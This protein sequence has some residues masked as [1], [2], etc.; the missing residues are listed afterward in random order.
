MRGVLQGAFALALAGCAAGGSQMQTASVAPG[1]EVKCIEDHY[2]DSRRCFAATFGKGDAMNAPFQVIY[3]NRLGPFLMVGYHTHPTMS[4]TVRVDD[5]KVHYIPT[6]NE[7]LAVQTASEHT[8]VAN[9]VIDDLVK[10]RTAYVTYY[11]WPSAIGKK[12]QVDLTGFAPAYEHLKKEI[13]KG[14]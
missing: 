3:Q 6:L 9:R 12:M 8:A 1:W 14:A 5:G 10:G 11:S 7:F 2:K 13:S 4:A